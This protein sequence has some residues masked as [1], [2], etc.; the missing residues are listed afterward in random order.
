MYEQPYSPLVQ[1]SGDTVMT[2]NNYRWHQEL[3]PPEGCCPVPRNSVGTAITKKIDICGVRE[4]NGQVNGTQPAGRGEGG[5]C[6]CC[7][8]SASTD[9]ALCPSALRTAT[10]RRAHPCGAVSSPPLTCPPV[11][12]AMRPLIYGYLRVVDD[13]DDR[14]VRRRERGLQAHAEAGGFCFVTTFHEYQTGYHGGFDELVAELRRAQARHVVVPSLEDLARHPILR[15]VM[16]GRLA[17]DADAH[18]WVVAP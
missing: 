7:L 13:R 11:Y 10:A 8:V 9:G 14:E 3:A 1:A 4:W 18:L 12:S 6:R 17:R 5:C 16:L 2:E 15:E